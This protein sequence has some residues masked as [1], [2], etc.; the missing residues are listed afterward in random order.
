ME[1]RAAF[2][3]ERSPCHKE[4]ICRSDVHECE[5]QTKSGGKKIEGR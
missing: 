5:S 4:A 2:E 3:E 1:R